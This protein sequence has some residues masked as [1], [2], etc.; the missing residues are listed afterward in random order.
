MITFTLRFAYRLGDGLVGQQHEF[1]DEFV[2]IFRH[3]EVG[4]HGLTR[5]VD[6]EVEFLTVELHGAVLEAGSTE[7][8]G[9]GIE[10]DQLQG[11]IA[12]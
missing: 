5:L 2:C 4:L 10:G 9:K 8:L 7:F 6:V 1:L 3:L 11:V 12:F